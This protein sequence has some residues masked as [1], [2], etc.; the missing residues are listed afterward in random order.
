MTEKSPQELYNERLARVKAA[1]A[2]QQPDQIPVFGPFQKYPYQFGGITFKQAMNDYPAARAACHKFLDYFQPDV[3]FGPIFAYPARAMESIGWK[4][5]K[6][7]GHGLDDDAMY[8]YVDGEYMTA[9][10]YDE[11]I[12]DPSDF[13]LR[14][15]AP[16]Q[17]TS[18]QGFAQLPP[19]RRFMWTGWMNIGAFAS[20][21]MQET[22]RALPKFSADINEWW[23]HQAEYWGEIGAKGYPLAFAAWDWPPFDIIGD[24]LRGTR[25]VLADMRRRPGKLHDALEKAT[26]IFIEY[27]S[28]A[29]GAPLPFTWIWVHKSTREFMSDA[30]FK[31]FYWPYL[32]K[33]LCALIDKGITPV[34]YWEADFES[35]LEHI[36]DVPSGKIIYHLSNTNFERAWDVLGGQVCLMGNV[37]NIMLLGGTPDDVRAYCKR[38]IDYTKGKPGLIMDAAVMLDEAKPENLKAMFDFTREY[39][40][41]R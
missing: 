32:R 27:G 29:A 6:W 33:G 8:Q 7:P 15:W 5:F 13:M 4:A 3:D 25:N 9:E 20:P 2:C 34:V 36:A 22:F 40:L 37:P 17:F 26:Q 31:E 18:M 30:Q 11:F 35:R 16:R 23:G 21:E 14:K 39:G 28:G 24:T 38:I 12:F 1:A 41:R 19:W 10:E